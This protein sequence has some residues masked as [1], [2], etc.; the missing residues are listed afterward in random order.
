MPSE[1]FSEPLWAPKK[2]Q[3]PPKSQ[4]LEE[5]TLGEPEEGTFGKSLA[6]KKT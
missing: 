5:G 3:E 6:I 2:L 4:K 1:T